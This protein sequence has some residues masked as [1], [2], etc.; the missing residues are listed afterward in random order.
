MLVFLGLFST[1]LFA[2]ERTVTGQVRSEED[3]SGLPGVNV[4]IMGTSQGTVTGIDGKY[5]LQVP[6]SETVLAFSYVGYKGQEVVVGNQS[7]IDITMQANAESLS[8]VVVT[9]LGIGREL[10]SLGYATQEVE[11]DILT[12]TNTANMGNLL[13]GQVAGLRVNN[14]TGIFQ[15]PTFELRGKSPLIVLDGI[16]IESEL[17]DVSAN[18]VENI[19]V[20]KG[21]TASALY[22]ARGRNGAILITTKRAKKEGLSISV[23]QSTMVSAGFTVFPETQ[24]QYGNGSNGQYEFWDGKDGGISDG[25]MIW[26]PKFEP[27]V[28]VPQWNSPILDNVTNEQIPWWGDVAGTQYDDKSRYSRVPTPWK[29]HNNLKDFLGTG[30]NTTTDFEIAFKSEKVNYRLSGRYNYQ[31]GQVPNSSLTTGGLNF[32]S[33]INLSKSLTLNTKLAYNKVYSPNYPRYGYGPKNH[34]YTILIW[35]GD[36]VNGRDLDA[37]HYIPG[38]EG[39]RQANFNYAWYN[40]VYF[41]AH[42]LNQEFDEDVLNGLATLK[43]DI[44][45][46]LS[47]QG[48]VSAVNEIIFQDM[49]SPKTYLNYGDPR[50]G[51]YKM[52]DENELRIDSDILATY[53]K[54]FGEKINLQIN[55]GASSYTMRNREGY[56]ATDGIIVPF[57][58]SLNNTRGNVK[59]SNKLEKE[60][61]RSIYATMSVD[62]FDGIFLTAAARNDWSSTL[63]ESNSSY[64]YPS[65]SASV[66]LSR[67]ITLPNMFDYLKV[68]GA[69]AEVSSGLNPYQI[70]PVYDY[71]GLY[72]GQTKLDYSENIVNPNIEPEKSTSFELGL[73]VGVLENRLSFDL[74]YYNVLDANQIIDLPVSQASGFENRKVNGNEF[75][76]KGFET[77]INANPFRSSNFSY[78]FTLNLSTRVTRLESVYGGAEKYG[79]YAVGERIDNF[80]STG[81]MKTADGELILSESNGLPTR[82]SYP[83]MHG[84][85]DPNWIFGF[86]NTFE[87]KKFKLM[88]G[89]DG[90]QGG[91]VRSLTVEK[92]WWGGKHPYSTE[93]R[94]A[95]YAAGE[96]VYV[97]EGVNQI[98]GELTRDTDGTVISDT[99]EYQPNT[100]AVSWQTWSQQYPY[101]ARVTESESKKFANVFDRSFIKLRNVTLT[102]DMSDLLA[103]SFIKGM[104]VSVYG[105]NLFILKKADIIDPD[106]GNDDNLQDPSTRYVGMR[107]G[108]KF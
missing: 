46:G 12:Q 86:I 81:W 64:F 88:V 95:E 51:D 53:S 73:A 62:F 32:N 94:D 47:L 97:P 19:N 79:N 11:G 3:A 83:Q 91:V 52:W 50:D 2:Q 37:H 9:A 31:K 106:Y 17:F 33:S 7:V 5:A 4:V 18:D 96:P 57:V 104:E 80:Y 30:V 84:H 42:E 107:I 54:S 58:Y 60:A 44:T 90:V 15:S 25:D 43:W 56:R 61:I 39:Y 6:S 102:Y 76:T 27:G 49:E 26:G 98:G 48:R 66:L 103:N 36:D 105:Y 14:P 24:T 74:T 8:E 21:T 23:N 99:R 20:L 72:G 100:T 55:A 65:A 108:L 35:M 75:R 59:A 78:D 16:P 38:Q 63:P 71:A 92:M 67:F 13:T 89:I 77:V 29:Y 82:D 40:N 1:A 22:G 68:S 45:E 34:M 69:W 28:M 85:L 41:A 70:S 93:Y 10:K 87:Y 101:R